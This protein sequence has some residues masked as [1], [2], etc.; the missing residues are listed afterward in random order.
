M[1]KSMYLSTRSLA[2]YIVDSKENDYDDVWSS[3]DEEF[4]PPEEIRNILKDTGRQLWDAGKEY[5]KRVPDRDYT[6]M[7][8]RALKPGIDQEEL[9]GTQEGRC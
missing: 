7:M 3:W 9:Y 6:N 2:N 4:Q 1:K 5:I 8:I